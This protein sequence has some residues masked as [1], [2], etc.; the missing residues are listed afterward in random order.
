MTNRSSLSN[1]LTPHNFGVA[2]C[3]IL[4]LI[5]P[6]LLSAWA[7]IHY[8]NETATWT[9]LVGGGLITVANV[10]LQLRPPP[11]G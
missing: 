4:L 2:A 5:L 1:L 9:L 7:G 6:A 3:G 8:P 10:L 11:K